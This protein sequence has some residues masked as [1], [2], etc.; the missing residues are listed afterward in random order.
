MG[1]VVPDLELDFCEGGSSEGRCGGCGSLKSKK[2]DEDS[3]VEVDGEGALLNST[4]GISSKFSRS[5]PGFFCGKEISSEF[6]V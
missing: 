6:G 5:A 1:V 4:C 2:L 3:V